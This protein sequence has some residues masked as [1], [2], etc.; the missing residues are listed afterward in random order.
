MASQFMNSSKIPRQHKGKQQQHQQRPAIFPSGYRFCPSESELLLNY[1]RNKILGLPLPCDVIKEVEI[2]RFNLDQFTRMIVEFTDGNGEDSYFF[3]ITD[4]KNRVGGRPSRT[5]SDGYWKATSGDVEVL[6]HGVTI[7]YKKNLVLYIGKGNTARKT[8]WIMHEYKLN[9]R[10]LLS[11]DQRKA[12]DSQMK[13]CVLC[14][15]RDKKDFSRVN[16]IETIQETST[17]TSL[18]ES[19]KREPEDEEFYTGLMTEKDHE[20]KEKSTKRPEQHDH[21][22]IQISEEHGEGMEELEE[23]EEASTKTCS[24]NSVMENLKRQRENDYEMKKERA[25]RPKHHDS[26]ETQINVEYREGMEELEGIEEASTKTWSAVPV[27][28]HHL[29]VFTTRDIS[30]NFVLTV[31]TLYILTM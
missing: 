5:T 28:R 10:L 26:N 25:K 3:T 17:R 29:K 16:R 22:E 4:P 14:R 9:Y 7:G 21:N 2:Y 19:L 23:I 8:N 27:V 12:L 18:M 1:L 6:F 20:T 13:N 15:I 11:D 30:E 24:W 31:V